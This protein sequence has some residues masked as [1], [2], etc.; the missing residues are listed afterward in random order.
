M[1]SFCLLIQDKNGLVFSMFALRL[2]FTIRR[3]LSAIL[4][5]NSWSFNSKLD[6]LPCF[7]FSLSL[8]CSLLSSNSC[9][10]SFWIFVFE[11]SAPNTWSAVLPFRYLFLLSL[12]DS[13][14]VSNAITSSAYC[15]SLNVPSS[16][17]FF[18]TS[19]LLL[20]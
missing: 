19:Y 5:F 2:S 9:S 1:P 14:A 16:S 8:K 20:A 15:C 13:T 17:C 12:T 10:L 6:F 3:L 11:I 4:S 7:L 18:K